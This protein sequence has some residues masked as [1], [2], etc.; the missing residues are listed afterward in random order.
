MVAAAGSTGGILAVYIG[1][2]RKLFR[3]SLLQKTKEK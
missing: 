2:F 3:L 1:R